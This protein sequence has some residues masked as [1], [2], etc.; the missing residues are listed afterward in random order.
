MTPAEAIASHRSMLNESGSTVTLK[1][2]LGDG[3][4]AVSFKARLLGFKPDNA[5]FQQGLTRVIFVA[6]DAAGFPL[7]IK[8]KS[9]DAI[10]IGQ[11]K[12]TVQVVDDFTRMIAG[13][14]VAYELW[15]KG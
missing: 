15:V 8:E 3:A 10:W 5:Q 2:G 14:L 4:P 1:R 6:E 12:M 9:T 13:V 11:R 7:P